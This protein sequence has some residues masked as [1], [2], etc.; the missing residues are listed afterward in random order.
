MFLRNECLIVNSQSILQMGCSR[1]QDPSQSK[2]V[3]APSGTSQVKTLTEEKVVSVSLAGSRSILSF[4]WVGI[5]CLLK[6]SLP[7]FHRLVNTVRAAF[8][9]A[10]VICW[11]LRSNCGRIWRNHSQLL[12]LSYS[13]CR[14]EGVEHCIYFNIIIPSGFVHSY[15][16]SI[17]FFPFKSPVSTFRQLFN[18]FPLALYSLRYPLK[19]SGF[20]CSRPAT[21][22]L[23]LFNWAL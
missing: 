1:C 10:F 4:F 11:E 14:I 19:V 20:S 15:L 23:L 17:V 9:T 5:L 18:T 22:F 2:E 6:E 13:R 8:I 21:Y 12:S 7:C 16:G 3:V